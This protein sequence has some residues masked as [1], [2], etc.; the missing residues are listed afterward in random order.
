MVVLC[1]R[2]FRLRHVNRIRAGIRP[3]WCFTSLGRIILLAA[4]LL[5]RAGEKLLFE[6]VFLLLVLFAVPGPAHY[7]RLVTK[8]ASEMKE[9]TMFIIQ[10]AS[11]GGSTAL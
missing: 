11:Q 1:W 9:N 10:A 6:L 5:A 4:G 3:G 8:I 2:R 7:L